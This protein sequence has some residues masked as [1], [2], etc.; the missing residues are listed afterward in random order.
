MLFLPTFEPCRI[1]QHFPKYD[2]VI[3]CWLSHTYRVDAGCEDTLAMLYGRPALYSA[4]HRETMLLGVRGRFIDWVHLG[5][6]IEIGSCIINGHLRLIIA[7]LQLLIPFHIVEGLIKIYPVDRLMVLEVLFG[8]LRAILEV[9]LVDEI[10]DVVV[11]LDVVFSER[12]DNLYMVLKIVP[13]LL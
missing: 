7:I 10:D 6:R 8:N 11:R 12:F 2:L 13:Y 9:H 4:E 3:L 1:D 5:V